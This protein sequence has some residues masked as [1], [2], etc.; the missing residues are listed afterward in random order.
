MRTIW[1]EPLVDANEE[2][3]HLQEAESE[4]AYLEEGR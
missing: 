4:L 1:Y 2:L 3:W